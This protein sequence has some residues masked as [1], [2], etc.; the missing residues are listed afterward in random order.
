MKLPSLFVSHGAPTFALQPGRA[1]QALRTLGTVLPRP[2]AV[3]VISPHWRTAGL[4][5]TT[6]PQP[7]TLHDFA[8]FPEVLYELRYPAP[9]QCRVA[10]QVLAC[11]TQAGFP[12][13]S[14][15]KR[16]F[17]HGCWTPLM[18]L[19]PDADV[20]VVQLSLPLTDSFQVLGEVGQ[21]L[22]PLREA[23]VLILASG[24]ITHNL[25]D[26]NSSP[27]DASGYA[28][29]FMEWVAHTLADGD[30]AALYD[31]RRLAPGAVRAHPSDEHLLPLF[32]AIGAAGEDWIRSVRL[33][34]GLIYGVLGMDAYAFGIP[35]ALPPIFETVRKTGTDRFQ[36]TF[37]STQPSESLL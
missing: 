20:P 21:A 32:V 19:F 14:N 8:G 34:G 18:H 5:V 7:P 13:R 6:H 4:E 17:D 2:R 22:S 31:Y 15:P 36:S 23:E 29:T 28:T 25:Y 1:G 24:S 35:E 16:G 3:L 26:L 11:L 30:L 12:A 37:V 9:G 10:Q 33:P 27:R